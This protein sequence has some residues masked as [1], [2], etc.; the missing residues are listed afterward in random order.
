M[1]KHTPQFWVAA[2]GV[3]FSFL[4]LLG[5]WVKVIG[6]LN[7]SISGLDASDGKVLGVIALV[8]AGFLALH[9][10]GRSKGNLPVAA[11]LGAAITALAVYEIVNVSSSASEVNSPLASAS[12]GWGLYACV[13]GGAALAVGSVLALRASRKARGVDVTAGSHDGTGDVVTP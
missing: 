4:G 11:V 7:V 5:P 13:I 6:L 12:A 1:R 3:L 9:A 2:A 10:A 8:A